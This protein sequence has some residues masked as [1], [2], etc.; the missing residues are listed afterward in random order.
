MGHYCRICGR[1]RPNEQFSGHGHRTHVC[2]K[3]QQRP[4]AE[5]QAIEQKDA[6]F[7]FLKQTHISKKN[8]ACLKEW[9]ASDNEEV[10]EFARIVLEVAEVKPYKKRRLKVLAQQRPDL[11]RK[12]DETGLIMAHHW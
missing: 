5:R 11:L 8:V 9:S 1:S 4:K 6:I 12:L 10:A 3:C 2:K 7:G